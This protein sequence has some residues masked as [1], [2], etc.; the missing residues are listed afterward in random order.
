MLPAGSA[1]A[2]DAI[3]A[4]PVDL[5]TADSAELESLPGVGPATAQSIIA[6]REEHGPFGTVDALVAVR[7]IGPATLEALRDHVVVG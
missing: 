5:N 6:H 2:T 1:A 3:P 7:G 4:G